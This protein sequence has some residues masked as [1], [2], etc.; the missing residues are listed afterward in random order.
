MTYTIPQRT[1]VTVVHEID[2]GTHHLLLMSDQSI[3][4]MSNEAV[5]YVADNVM[6]L[7]TCE[8]YRLMLSLQ[9]MFKEIHE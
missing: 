9:E 1:D 7:D 2:L 5:S 8:A 3:D 6:S 4:V